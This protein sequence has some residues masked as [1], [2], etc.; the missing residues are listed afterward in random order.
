MS[1]NYKIET[2]CIQSGW[3]PTKGEPRVLPIYQSTT[4]KYDTSEQMGRLFD[5]E[6]S[7]Y[8]YTRLQNPT[9]DAVAQ[10]ITELEGG[11]AGMLTSSGQAANYYA[12]FNIC[13]AG[14]HIVSASTIYGGTFNLYGTTMKKMGVDLSLIHI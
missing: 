2:K 14:D 9:N 4:F 10:K 6:D 3:Q 12:V 1:N 5:L 13:E 11:V 7:G 8:F